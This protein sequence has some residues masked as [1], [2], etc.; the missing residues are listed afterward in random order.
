M[1]KAVIYFAD[2][3][4]VKYVCVVAVSVAILLDCCTLSRVLI[5]SGLSPTIFPGIDYIKKVR[6]RAYEECSVGF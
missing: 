5:L 6:F 3:T 1:I 4:I 2:A